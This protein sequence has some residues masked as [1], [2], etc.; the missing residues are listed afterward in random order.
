MQAHINVTTTDGARYTGT[1]DTANEHTE[2]PVMLAVSI[3][4]PEQPQDNFEATCAYLATLH[5]LKQEEA[6]RDELPILARAGHSTKTTLERWAADVAKKFVYWGRVAEYL[7]DARNERIEH[8]V[9]IPCDPDELE[10][11]FM[12]N[13]NTK[14]PMAT[15]LHAWPQAFFWAIKYYDR[16]N[17]D[18]VVATID[19]YMSLRLEGRTVEEL[20]RALAPALI[21]A[22][23]AHT[24]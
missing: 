10:R 3:V 16:P 7:L 2:S 13:R 17:R 6:C 12:A 20:A 5:V 21:D 1:I 8:G 24:G 11:A 18:D 14:N 15:R 4:C 9:P 22:A 23:L 19:D